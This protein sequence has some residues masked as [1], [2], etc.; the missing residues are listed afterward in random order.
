MLLPAVRHSN[1]DCHLTG[2]LTKI[3][4]L[5]PEP[6]ITS[7]IEMNQI[8]EKGFKALINYKDTQ[9]KILVRV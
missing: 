1:H 2:F 9:V 5:N 7:L 3:G 6:M 4:D 8:E